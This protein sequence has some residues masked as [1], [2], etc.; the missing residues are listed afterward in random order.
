[1]IVNGYRHSFKLP[2][3]VVRANNVYGIR[4][5]PEKLIPRCIM[6]LIEGKKIPL[7]G[8]GRNVRHYLAATDFAAALVLLA[9]KGKIY[10]TY[11]IGS[12]EEYPNWEVVHFICEEFG[13]DFSESIAF[14]PDR[15]FNDRRYSISWNKI[16][17]L[18]WAPRHS[19]R[20]EIP[21]IVAWYKQNAP[22]LAKKLQ[23]LT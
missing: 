13:A 12:R 15:P 21:K 20:T 18:G 23:K 5:F 1:M 9:Q 11:N 22:V 3:V 4:Q 7:H 17:E 14:V 10:E 8:D 2:V 6:S 19:L 16:S